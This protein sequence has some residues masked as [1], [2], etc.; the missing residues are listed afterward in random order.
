MREALL[1]TAQNVVDALVPAMLPFLDKPFLFFGHSMGAL[2]SYECA[3]RLQQRHEPGPA[4]LI[5]SARVAPHSIPPR[6]PLHAL[7][8][9]E[10]VAGLKAMNGTP[11]EVFENKELL[12]L[13]LPMLRADFAISEA[14]RYES[15]EKL[16]CDIV[17]F[18]GLR[19]KETF[20]SGLMEWGELTSG[21]FNLRMLPGDH[22]YLRNEQSAFLRMLSAEIYQ[23]VSRDTSKPVIPASSMPV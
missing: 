18:G 16:S 8:E 20:R 4:R 12:D 23:A 17:A 3:R 1:S 14:Y 21:S 22:F 6:P 7:P 10:F 5:V 9:D 13:V 2:I 19:D 11:P 15:S